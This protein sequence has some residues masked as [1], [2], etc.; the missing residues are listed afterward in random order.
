MSLV[1]AQQTRLQSQQ[2]EIKHC[3]NELKYWDGATGASGPGR[4]PTDVLPSQLEA[5]IS[6]VRR[7]EEAASKNEE[8]LTVIMDD[9]APGGGI[10]GELDQL[11]HRL[12]MTDIELQKTNTTLRRLSEEMRCYSLEKTK[13]REEELRGEVDR[14]HAEIKILQKTNEDSATISDKLSREVADVEH[15]ILARKGEVEK[16]IADMKSANLESLTISPPEET[17]AFLD[18]ISG[19]SK[20]GT[21]RKML[22]SPRQLENAV[23]TSKN[24]HGVWV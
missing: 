20:P 22:G 4:P 1:Q 13:E 14:I 24:P 5:V 17:K 19:P 21:T 11:K 23:P 2:A 8:E 9:R 7:L 6:E 10:R 16:L 3:D 15:A 12:E 18:D